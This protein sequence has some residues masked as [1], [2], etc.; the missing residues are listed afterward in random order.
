MGEICAPW[1][2]LWHFSL[3]DGQSETNDENLKFIEDINHNFFPSHGAKRLQDQNLKAQSYESVRR[4]AKLKELGNSI[5]FI[6]LGP[7]SAAIF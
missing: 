4:F 6:R 1:L 3:S 5:W 7:R 2:E